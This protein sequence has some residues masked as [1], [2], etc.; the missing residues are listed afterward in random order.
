MR[1][2]ALG[3]ACPDLVVGIEDRKVPP[4]DLLARI[5]LD[6]PRPRIPGH[7]DTLGVE[8][9]DRVFLDR[10]DEQAQEVGWASL[11]AAA[12][13]FVRHSLTASSRVAVSLRRLDRP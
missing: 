11:P 12:G 6:A 7:H 1:Q 2:L 13:D 9:Q 3:L 10:I 4:D 8:H 5:A